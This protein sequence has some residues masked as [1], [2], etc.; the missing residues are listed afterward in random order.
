MSKFV[1]QNDA[2]ERAIIKYCPNW[3]VISIRESRHFKR[4]DDEPGEMQ[5]HAYSCQ[6]KDWKRAS[7]CQRTL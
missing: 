3:I 2:K 1:E 5:I 7:H 4:S 6:A